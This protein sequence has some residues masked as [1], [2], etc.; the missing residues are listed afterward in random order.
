MANRR[1]NMATSAVQHT[2]NPVDAAAPLH[3]DL[4]PELEQV[5]LAE[6]LFLTTEEILALSGRL[7]LN[8][9][10]LV[11]W[12]SMRRVRIGHVM[13]PSYWRDEFK[14]Y[15][16]LIA[17]RASHQDKLKSLVDTIFYTMHKYKCP[18]WEQ[19]VA[20]AQLLDCGPEEVAKRI[21]TLRVGDPDLRQISAEEWDE[22]WAPLPETGNAGGF[23]LWGTFCQCRTPPSEED[24][25]KIAIA[26]G[27]STMHVKRKFAVFRSYAVRK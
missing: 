7:N 2:A 12:F 16:R 20:L 24:Y 25:L 26:H 15:M 3:L 10:G 22:R 18:T 4:S 13:G 19:V 27:V 21:C 9:L 17:R 8:P 11:H 14:P 23:G 6:S 1:T 5:L